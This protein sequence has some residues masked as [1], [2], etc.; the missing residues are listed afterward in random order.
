MPS[1]R[2][3]IT[4]R[5]FL[6]GMIATSAAAGAFEIASSKDLVNLLAAIARKKL[7]ASAR[8]QFQQRRDIRRTTEESS[9]VKKLVDPHP[10]PSQTA[11]HQELVQKMFN[12]LSPEERQLADFRRSGLE[13]I[14]IAQRVGG[15]AQARRMQLARGIERISKELGLDNDE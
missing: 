10:T 1:T 15:T 9:M 4:R 13:W 7:A 8:A 5:G 11:A 12:S 14:E 3:S 2:Q 6:T